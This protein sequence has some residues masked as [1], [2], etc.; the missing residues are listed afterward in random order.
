VSVP[1]HLAVVVVVVGGLVSACGGTVSPQSAATSPAETATA[2]LDTPTPSPTTSAPGPSPSPTPQVTKKK[3][4]KPRASK[5][6][7]K[8]TASGV[9]PVVAALLQQV[10][11]ARAAQGLAP[12]TLSS[13][14][15]LSAR[16]HTLKMAGSCGLQHQCSGEAGLGDRITAA[17]VHWSAVGEN[18]GEGGPI[19]TGNT[20]ATKMGAALIRSMLAEKAPDDGHRRNILSSSFHHIGISVYWTSSGTLWLTQ[21]FSN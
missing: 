21:D 8:P 2:A 20:A 11:K 15:M 6:S 13:G 18:I 12:Y 1:R 9:N 3:S 17:G 14:L 7:A 5:T 16:R 10:N 19:A 4:P